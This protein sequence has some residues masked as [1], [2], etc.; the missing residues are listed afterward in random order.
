MLA[1]RDRE[2]EIAGLAAIRAFL[3]DEASLGD[4]ANTSN[5]RVEEP[6]P[7]SPPALL[8]RLPRMQCCDMVV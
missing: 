4:D 6:T 2:H 8:M 5:A 1:H 3:A 7:A